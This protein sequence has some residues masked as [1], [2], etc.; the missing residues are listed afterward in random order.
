MTSRRAPARIRRGVPVPAVLKDHLREAALPRRLWTSYRRAQVEREY[1]LRREYYE[2]L[3]DERGIAYSLE[4]TTSAVRVRLASRGYT[5]A[6]RQ[7]GEIHTFACVPLVAWHADL[8]TELRELGPVTH[9]DYVSRGFSVEAFARGASAAAAREAMLAQLR[10][11][12]EEAHARQPVDWLFCYGGGQDFSPRL[13]DEL[14]A[15]YGVPTAN[16]SL[17]DKQGWAGEDAGGWRTGAA[18]V[19]SSFDLFATS[20]R[21]ACEWHLVEG[22]RPVHLP[23]GYCERTYH[24]LGVQRDLDVSFVGASYGPRRDVVDELRRHG[25]GVHAF[26][27]GWPNGWATDS[28]AI[29]NRTK[30]NLGMGGVE[31]SESLTTVKGRDFEVPAAGGGLYLTSFDA[32]LARSFVIGEEIVCYGSRDELL[33]Q[34]R[35][36]LRHEDEAAAIAA[37]ARARCVREHRWLHRFQHLLS[38]LGI[39]Q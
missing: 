33:E 14:T 39:T 32:D 5:P 7:R 16:L 34:V 30:I 21:V 4:N 27:T 19:T 26:G 11:A 23:P 36:F 25:V 22:G 8:V 13:I 29:F 35:H 17:D 38:I 12:F 9:F 10:T 31:Y 2:R 1:R 20:S 18:D 6:K 15:T 37:R 3:A 28:N 24:P